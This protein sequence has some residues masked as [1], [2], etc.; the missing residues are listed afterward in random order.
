MPQKI[1]RKIHKIDAS[2]KA[3]GRLA[4]EVAALLIGKGKPEF[5]PRLDVGDF[6]QIAN[7]DKVKFSGK[8]AEQKQ[9]YRHS[10]FVGGL[11]TV[12]LKD[13]IEQEEYDK[14]L[15]MSVDKMLPRN[16]FKRARIKRLSFASNK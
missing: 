5:E 11:K 7:I 10:G 12:K 3:L 16:K 8:K 1:E 4:T 13:L 6:V 14:I 9:Y 2:G 15:K